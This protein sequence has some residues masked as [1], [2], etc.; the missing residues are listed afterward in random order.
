MPLD[1]TGKFALGQGYFT[2]FFAAQGIYILAVPYYQ[3][4]LGI[5]PFLLGLAMTLPLLL[6]GSLGPLVNSRWGS[7]QAGLISSNFVWLN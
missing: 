5:D 4:T 7:A 1:T 6:A 2:Q 3:M